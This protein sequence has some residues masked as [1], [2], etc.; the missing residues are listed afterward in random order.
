[1]YFSYKFQKIVSTRNHVPGWDKKKK[2]REEEKFLKERERTFWFLFDL[3][4]LQTTSDDSLI[5]S[6]TNFETS[7]KHGNNSDVELNVLKEVLPRDYKKPIE[8]LDF[9]KTMEAVFSVDKE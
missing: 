3:K 8:V 7:L 4:K 1:M 2:K 5:T 6:C 9:F